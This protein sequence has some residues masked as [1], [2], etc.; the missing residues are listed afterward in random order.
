MDPRQPS[1]YQ[2]PPPMGSHPPQPYSQQETGENAPRSIP[3]PPMAPPSYG[4]GYSFNGYSPVPATP[5]SGHLPPSLLT[6]SGVGRSTQY[7]GGSQ[8][9]FPGY[10]TMP[11]PGGSMFSSVP[12]GSQHP[13][14]HLNIIIPS[15]SAPD[16]NQYRSLSHTPTSASS[17]SALPQFLRPSG[18][19]CPSAFKIPVHVHVPQDLINVGLTD[20]TAPLLVPFLRDMAR[21]AN[22]MNDCLSTMAGR[23]EQYGTHLEELLNTS[24]RAEPTPSNSTTSVVDTLSAVESAVE[25]E[26]KTRKRKRISGGGNVH[27]D[28]KGKV[29]SVFWEMIDLPRKG[30]AHARWET[31]KKRGRLDDGQIQKKNEDGKIVWYPHWGAQADAPANIGFIDAVAN[32]V[33]SAE[34]QSRD[35]D[36]KATIEDTAFNIEVLRAIAQGYFQTHNGVYSKLQTPDGQAQIN[37]KKVADNLRTA[38]R[39]KTNNRRE[40]AAIAEKEHNI[41]GLEQF[42]GTDGASQSESCDETMPPEV[43]KRFEECG[44]ALNSGARMVRPLAQRSKRTW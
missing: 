29:H 7:L 19:L 26:S 28:A 6:G 8:S 4:P 11:G 37:A 25:P 13:P 43:Q 17:S 44:V 31:A 10:P 2:E 27:K 24:R 34:K 15:S 20:V 32:L 30:L 36:S 18:T 9:S 23:L 38:R 5:A 35:V 14:P 40:E 1:N 39:N 42:L 41:S 33:Y 3:P 22:E 16:S 21:H 12:S